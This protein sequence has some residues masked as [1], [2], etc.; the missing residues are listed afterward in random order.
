MEIKGE[1]GGGGGGTRYK[2]RKKKYL[3]KHMK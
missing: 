2:I 3:T 1:G